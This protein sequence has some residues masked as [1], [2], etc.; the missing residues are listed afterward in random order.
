MLIRVLRLISSF[1]RFVPF[2]RV[3]RSHV[4]VLERLLR[5]VDVFDVVHSIL[6]LDDVWWLH[7]GSWLAVDQALSGKLSLLDTIEVLPLFLIL[8]LCFLELDL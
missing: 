4:V 1:L 6:S 5:L 7:A 8:F 2:A 3:I